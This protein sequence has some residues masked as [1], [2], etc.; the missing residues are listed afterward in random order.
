MLMAMG[1]LTRKI[2][3]VADTVCPKDQYGTMV[4]YKLHLILRWCNR[5]LCR[6][7]LV[8][9]FDAGNMT[10]GL[11]YSSSY[12][13][14]KRGVAIII[15]PH[16]AFKEENYITD[17][18]GRFILV[19]GKIESITVSFLNVYYPPEIGLDFMS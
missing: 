6:Y 19:V 11:I 14:K 2:T 10:K 18:E 3:V 4:T 9:G 15:Q 16:V 12:G 1:R 7:F 17:K 5:N 8:V 13:S